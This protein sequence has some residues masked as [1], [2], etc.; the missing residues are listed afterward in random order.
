MLRLLI[1]DITVERSIDR[2]QALLHI[3]W[4]GGSLEDL[5]VNLPAPIADRLRYPDCIVVKVRSLAKKLPDME[6]ASTL[7]QKG[8]LSAKKKPFTV[9]MIRWIR[10]KHRIPAYQ[11]KK[12]RPVR[13]GLSNQLEI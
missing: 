7:N 6:I 2:K 9:S 5:V 12:F 10:Y 4:Q 11:Y 3:R 13:V 1:K 8:L